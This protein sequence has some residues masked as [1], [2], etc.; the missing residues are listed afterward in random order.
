MS[1]TARMVS[2]LTSR[3][4]PTAIAVARIRQCRTMYPISRFTE[5]SKTVVVWS[6]VAARELG[7]H[8]AGPMLLLYGI[9]SEH[10]CVAARAL[11]ALGDN[12]AALRAIVEANIA[13]G[14]QPGGSLPTMTPEAD[15]VVDAAVADA[16]STGGERGWIGTHHLLRALIEVDHGRAGDL[17]RERGIVAT[18][19]LREA[20]RLLNSGVDE[21]AVEW[22]IP[23]VAFSSR[24]D[25]DGAGVPPP[26]LW[27]PSDDAMAGA[28]PAK[29]W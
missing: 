10:D 25:G 8:Q 14:S 3:Q 5:R 1:Q 16:E 13:D 28:T 19:V 12:L 24:D 2:G 23:T 29:R 15:A 27:P 26:H 7:L 21:N 17:L 6:N 22:Y 20:E 11:E 4:H 9:V 18:D